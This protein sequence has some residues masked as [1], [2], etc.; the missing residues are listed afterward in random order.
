MNTF[1]YKRNQI[2]KISIFDWVDSFVKNSD[3]DLWNT[4]LQ[5]EISSTTLKITN[6]EGVLEDTYIAW[7]GVKDTKEQVTKY[8]LMLN[9][10]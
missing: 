3:F 10:V 9:P 8:V 7:G 6:L 2:K 1:G 4:I 5:Q